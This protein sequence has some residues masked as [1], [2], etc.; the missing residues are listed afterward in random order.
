MNLH[1]LIQDWD[2]EI[3]AELR[4]AE[5]ERP[6]IERQIL[7]A[8]EAE[9]AARDRLQAVAA[10]LGRS[11]PE[12]PFFGS[13]G[14][15]VAIGNRFRE[16]QQAIYD[17]QDRVGAYRGQL[18]TLQRRI[19]DLVEALALLEHAMDQL[20]PAENPVQDAPVTVA[21]PIPL[22]RGPAPAAA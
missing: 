7:E 11:P 18:E 15:P 4:Q 3:T 21:M 20:G 12:G 8:Q 22:H 16:L 19:R 6:E 2:R 17:A 1:E 13:G 14:V 10:V 5:D 9:A